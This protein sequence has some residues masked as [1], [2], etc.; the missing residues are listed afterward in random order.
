MPP[1]R[2]EFP[3][4]LVRGEDRPVFFTGNAVNFQ[5]RNSEA[6]HPFDVQ[7]IMTK[8]S[9]QFCCAGRDT[10]IDQESHAG[11]LSREMLKKV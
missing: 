7:D 4:A 1:Q 6:V 3:K 2:V 10:L 9:E 8:L 11:A 5:I